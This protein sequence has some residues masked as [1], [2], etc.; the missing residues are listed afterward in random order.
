MKIQ[1]QNR[2]AHYQCE[3]NEVLEQTQMLQN[4][5]PGLQDQ[6]INM[7]QY[8]N[9]NNGDRKARTDYS[10]LLQR[11]N[12]ISCTIRRNQMRLQTLQRQIMCENQKIINQQQRAMMTA[13]GVRGRSYYNRYG[14]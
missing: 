3:Y 6:L 11:Y 8:L 14:Y 5:L 4:Q 7:Q 2:L 13:S 10:K 1:S 12:S 9:C